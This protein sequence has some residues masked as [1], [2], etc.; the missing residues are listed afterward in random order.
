[1]ARAGWAEGR[2][3]LTVA[4]AHEQHGVVDEPRAAEGAQGVGDPVAV[5]L[6]G[7]SKSGGGQRAAT[8]EA[9]AP[10]ARAPQQEK[11]LQREVHVPQLEKSL[12]SNEDP[13]SQK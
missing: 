7:E 9:R 12:H 6:R 11:P 13:H 3:E 1:M 8:T 4:I 5:E 2:A 10:R